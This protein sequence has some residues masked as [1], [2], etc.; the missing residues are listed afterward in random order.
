VSPTFLVLG[1]KDKDKVNG[2][3]NN[4]PKWLLEIG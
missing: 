1:D 2:V 4:F 3:E